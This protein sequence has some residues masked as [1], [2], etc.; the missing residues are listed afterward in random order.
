MSSLPQIVAAILAIAGIVM[1]TYADG[2]HSHTVMGIAL[3]V[4]SASM[5]A[6]YKVRLAS[7]GAAG[8]VLRGPPSAAGAHAGACASG[9]ALLALGGQGRLC[10]APAA[11]LQL[12]R[13]PV[14]GQTF[15][16][17][18]IK[19]VGQWVCRVS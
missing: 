2:F 6:L 9:G 16:A 12:S 11:W 19:W 18:E 3:V 14:S 5:S 1:M 7:F 4:G 10:R 8:T 13:P 15:A 17:C